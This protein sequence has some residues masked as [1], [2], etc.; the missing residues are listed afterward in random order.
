[1]SK[2]YFV[3]GFIRPST[4]IRIPLKEC[5]PKKKEPEF[6]ENDTRSVETGNGCQNTSIRRLI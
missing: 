2:N 6:T 1:M 3:T 5:V 4:Y